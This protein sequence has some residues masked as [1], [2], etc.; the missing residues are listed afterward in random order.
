MPRTSARPIQSSKTDDQQS[1]RADNELLRDDAQGRSDHDDQ[2]DQH[3]A[4]QPTTQKQDRVAT[5]PSPNSM[6]PPTVAAWSHTIHCPEGWWWQTLAGVRDLR[7]TS[8]QSRKRSGLRMTPTRA[9]DSIDTLY[10]RW[11]LRSA[12][13]DNKPINTTLS[14]RKLTA[15]QVTD[16]KWILWERQWT[17]LLSRQRTFRGHSAKYQIER[18]N[19]KTPWNKLVWRTKRY[20]DRYQLEQAT[21]W[22]PTREND[23]SS[24]IQSTHDNEPQVLLDD[25]PARCHRWPAMASSS[26]HYNTVNEQGNT[27]LTGLPQLG[28]RFNEDD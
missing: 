22:Y 3:S 27:E 12:A 24:T 16:T 9:D 18:W 8:G 19:I 26:K 10:R 6:R 1:Q 17:S 14:S 15:L 25:T 23:L 4:R 5:Q 13:K 11:P 2:S 7:S 20:T 28:T 21:I